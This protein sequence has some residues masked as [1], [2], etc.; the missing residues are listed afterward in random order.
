[1]AQS[2]EAVY[3]RFGGR[4]LNLAYRMT[5]NE[6]VARDLAQD[7]WIK[8]FQHFESFESRSDVFTWIH[9]ITVNH[10]I[11]YLKRERRVRWMRLLDRSVGEVLRDEDIA[12]ELEHSAT[13]SADHVL[14]TDERAQHVWD[15]I[16]TLDM[17]YRVALVLHHY[18]EMSYEQVA[19]TLQIS[20]SAV[21]A[22]IHRAR[23]QLT[24]AL[25][26]L[27]DKL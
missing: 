7:I 16:Q 2:F 1:M 20:M 19:E 14:E 12:R 5:G 6:E 3:E 27:L 22:R 25:G 24:K 9:R 21:E 13:P 17:K 10:V 4:V 23:K 26:P 18:E 15:A 8:V 11:N